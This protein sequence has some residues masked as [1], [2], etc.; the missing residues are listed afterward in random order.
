MDGGPVPEQFAGVL[1]FTGSSLDMPHARAVLAE[2]VAAIPRLR[3]RLVRTPPGCGPP[4][5]VDD[6]H[7][8]IR[9]HVRQV[10]CGA[11]GDERALL[12]TV[13]AI[14]TERLPRS[15]P[16]WSAVFITG[17][18]DDTVALTVVIHHVL[19]DG[20]GGLAVL[21]ELADGSGSRSMARDCVRPFPLPP[22]SVGRLA[23]DALAGRLRAVSHAPAAWRGLRMSMGA[24][25]GLHPARASACSLVQPTGPRRRLGMVCADRAALRASAHRHG[26]TV[27]DAVLTAVAGALHRLLVSRSESVNSFAVAVPVTARRTA[28]ASHLGNQ[29]APLLITVRGTGNP[30]HRIAE[31]A[32]AVRAGKASATG[33]PP[34]AVLGPMFRFAAALGGYRWYMRHQHRIHTL[35][36]HVRGPDEPI[37]FAG[38]TVKAIIPVAVGEAGNTTISF[39]VLSYADAVAITA[40]T[41]ADLVPDLSTLTDALR[42]E[43]DSIT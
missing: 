39:T 33:L 2:R 27:N 8:D 23:V 35:V 32:A 19:A 40:I 30:G 11:P 21:A 41:D 3:Q 6:A 42:A 7:F 16:L 34:I 9:R 10:S 13:G 24:G 18:A 37:A 4:I 17:L 28:T 43:L 25:G 38:S 22:P 36:S 14:V 12:D 5:W 1:V 20:I 26:G 31:V 15:R 29:V